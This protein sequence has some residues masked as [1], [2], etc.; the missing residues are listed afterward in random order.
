MAD[1]TAAVV[2]LD[3]LIAR[4]SNDA[5]LWHQRGLALAAIQRWVSAEESFLK[6]KKLGHGALAYPLLLV[7]LQLD[8]KETAQQ[9]AQHLLKTASQSSDPEQLSHAL[10]A[11]LA[12]PDAVPRV[13]EVLLLAERVADKNK[14][15]P[16]SQALLGAALYRAGK[17]DEA[18]KYLEEVAR[19]PRGAESAWAHRFLALAYHKQ[20]KRDEARQA[21]TRAS[22]A[23]EPP[24]AAKPLRR[25]LVL[26]W[27][28]QLELD[29]LQAEV[30]RT[31]AIQPDG[32]RDP[33]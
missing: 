12:A 25:P 5:D 9:T 29:L 30:V 1:G 3:A 33:N 13:E 15:T 19:T 16:G 24:P 32:E 10:R 17:L 22:Q 6:A 23:L 21:L 31:L 14:G 7:Q 2:H 27:M 4:E 20:G 11:C 28:L 26:P 8:K 18:L